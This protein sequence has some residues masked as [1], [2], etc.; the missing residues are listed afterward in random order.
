MS[1]SC[2]PSCP[3]PLCLF[4]IY[5]FYINKAESKGIQ[6][7]KN[8]QDDNYPLVNLCGLTILFLIRPQAETDGKAA[9]KLQAAKNKSLFAVLERTGKIYLC[10]RLAGEPNYPNMSPCQSRWTD[11]ATKKIKEKTTRSFSQHLKRR[12]KSTDVAGKRI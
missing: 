4:G 1:L 7:T 8:P 12:G 3:T 5:T 2:F 11:G 9:E 6:G 10:C